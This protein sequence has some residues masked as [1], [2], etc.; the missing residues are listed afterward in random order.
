MTEVSYI[1][2]RF[3]NGGFFLRWGHWCF[4]IN[5]SLKFTS[6]EGLVSNETVAS[7]VTRCT[8]KIVRLVW[9]VT[10]ASAH[11]FFSLNI[12][13]IM[14][15]GKLKQDGNCIRIRVPCYDSCQCTY[16]KISSISR[17]KYQSLNVDCILLQ[18][19]SLK[20]LKPGVKLRMKM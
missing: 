7:C 6:T 19:S 20:P 16:R 13:Y 11:K 3:W 1:K 12:Y 18:L 9:I 5:Q 2:L 15:Y 17:T 4:C 10:G 8:I 14:T